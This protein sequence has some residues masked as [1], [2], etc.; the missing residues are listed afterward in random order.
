MDQLGKFDKTVHDGIVFDDMDFTH[1]NRNAQIHISDVARSRQL[2]IR[3][4]TAVLPKG[5]RRIFT[6]NKDM[7]DFEDEAIKRRCKVIRVENNLY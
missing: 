5:V 2:H 3:Y 6:G 4:T 1:L 7:F